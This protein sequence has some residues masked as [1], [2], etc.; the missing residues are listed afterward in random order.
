VDFLALTMM[1]N[2]VSVGSAHSLLI[3]LRG[4]AFIMTNRNVAP[5]QLTTVRTQVTTSSVPATVHGRPYRMANTGLGGVARPV[6]SFGSI[7]SNDALRKSGLMRLPR[8]RPE[9]TSILHL[10]RTVGNGAVNRTLNQTR[11]M[12]GGSVQRAPS[13]LGRAVP[14]QANRPVERPA[15][16]VLA[17]AQIDAAI[18]WNNRQWRGEERLKMLTALR[19]MSASAGSSFTAED[20]QRVTKMQMTAGLSADGRVDDQTAVVLLQDAGKL[21]KTTKPYKAQDV[22]LIFYPGELEN[23]DAWKKTHALT[24][25]NWRTLDGAT[26][27]P[28]PGKGKLYVKVHGN[29]VA[30]Y[31]A[32][33]GPPI[34]FSDGAAHTAEPTPAG[35]YTLGIGAPHV[36]RAW[37]ASQIAFGAALRWAPDGRNVQFLSP[38]VRTWQ[39]ATQVPGTGVRSTLANPFTPDDL[40]DPDHLLAG[41][42]KWH[43]DLPS[44]Y[45]LN[46]FG[47]LAWRLQQRRKGTP[48]LIHTTPMQEQQYALGSSIALDT[49]HGCL[50]IQPADRDEMIKH[51]FLQ[52]GV[53]LIVKTYM[54]HLMPSALRSHEEA[55][56]P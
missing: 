32:R 25:G 37:S 51:G 3:F 49:S 55:S 28:P 26:V 22:I 14:R 27:V 24:G 45:R 35:T 9:L 40:L 6:G 42:T 36:T 31:D 4:A 44:E 18:A 23:L 54:M 30:M 48:Y 50:H 7:D 20:A 41:V 13:Q 12:V 11:R 8:L 46:D 33:G 38:D 53:K 16:A 10:Q 19:K 15:S 2:S 56:K 29:V 52:A 43:K 1:N 5:R 34:K 39:Y 21:A 17:A 47:A